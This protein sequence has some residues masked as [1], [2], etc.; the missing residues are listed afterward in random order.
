M[1]SLFVLKQVATH[2]VTL[3]TTSPILLFRQGRTSTLSNCIGNRFFCILY[4]KNIF[5]SMCRP[6]YCKPC[7]VL[8]EELPT[9]TS[10]VVTSSIIMFN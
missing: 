7:T 6:N 1:S 2:S 3:P 5:Q 9:A 8:L 10:S 4:K